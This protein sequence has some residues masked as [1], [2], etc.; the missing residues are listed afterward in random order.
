MDL[1]LVTYHACLM[2]VYIINFFHIYR[3][4]QM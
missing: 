4:N 3:I 1:T 2:N